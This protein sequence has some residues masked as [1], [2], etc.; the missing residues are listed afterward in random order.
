[1]TLKN[2]GLPKFKVTSRYFQEALPGIMQHTKAFCLQPMY[3]IRH[4]EIDFQELPLINL[5]EVGLLP[6]KIKVG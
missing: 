5:I 3:L 4:Q 1:M 6:L 2:G